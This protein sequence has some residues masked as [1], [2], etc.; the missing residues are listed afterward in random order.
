[1]RSVRALDTHLKASTWKI[2]IE[3]CVV[4]GLQCSV[5]TQAAGLSAECY[6]LT[7]GPFYTLSF[8]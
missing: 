7:F 8:N 1:M 6:F 4:T 5:K 2:E 3:F